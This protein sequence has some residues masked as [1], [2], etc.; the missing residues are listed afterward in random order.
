[1]PYLEL[2]I[3]TPTIVK[4]YKVNNDWRLT[5]NSDSGVE[6]F[7][8]PL[9]DDA[10]QDIIKLV[11]EKSEVEVNFKIIDDGEDKSMLSES[12]GVVSI[13]QQMKYLLNKFV[14]GQM[15]DKGFIAIRDDSGSLIHEFEGAWSFINMSTAGPGTS[16]FE[17]TMRLYVGKLVTA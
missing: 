3:E 15:D 16:Y 17:C 7:L 10:E 2:R 5:V 14:T 11:G 12:G 8:L 6:Q 9:R 13:W 4:K 1:M